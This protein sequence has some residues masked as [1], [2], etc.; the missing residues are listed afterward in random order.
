MDVQMEDCQ[1]W[2][3]PRRI[4]C[5][6][7]NNLRLF[8]SLISL[9]PIKSFGQTFVRNY[10]RRVFYAQAETVVAS[11]KHLDNLELSYDCTDCVSNV[12]FKDELLHLLIASIKA[13][14][15]G[16]LHRAAERAMAKSTTKAINDNINKHLAP[17]FKPLPPYYQ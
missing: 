1:K 11:F 6:V 14:S 15:N 17:Y 12:H 13:G 7:L 9:D 16:I 10:A 2:S 3:L 8:R 5:S 4:G